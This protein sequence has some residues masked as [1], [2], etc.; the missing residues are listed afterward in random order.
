MQKRSH[1]PYPAPFGVVIRTLG[2]VTINV[3]ANFEVPIYTH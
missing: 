3:R 1:E 2:L